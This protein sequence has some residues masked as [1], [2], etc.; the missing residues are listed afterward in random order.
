M[1]FVQLLP[2]QYVDARTYNMVLT[3]CAEARDLRNAR[4]IADMCLASGLKLDTVMYTN[5]IK[6]EWRGGGFGSQGVGQAAGSLLVCSSLMGMWVGR[7]VISGRGI[8]AQREVSL[9]LWTFVRAVCAAAGNAEAAFSTYR[10]M[11]E[12][13]VRSERQVYATLVSACSEQI[14]NTHSSDRRTALVLVERAFGVVE[15]MKAQRILPDVVVWNTLVTAAGRAGQL[16]R[17]FA[18]LEEMLVCVRASER[19]LK[20]KR[21]LGR[22]GR[23]CIAC[24]W[25]GLFGASQGARMP[26]PSTLTLTLPVALMHHTQLASFD[27]PPPPP[28][29]IRRSTA[30]APTTARTPP[31]SMPVPVRGTRTWPLACMPRPLGSVV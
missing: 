31:S 3:V 5:L 23:A 27:P 7:G 20:K 16:Q 11:R 12:A 24:T 15:D 2:R 10:E 18:V 26:V 6:G 8:R 9:A 21:A 14:R 30:A 1:R 25:R 29:P 22:G 19:M 4:H 17:A 13:G 28:A